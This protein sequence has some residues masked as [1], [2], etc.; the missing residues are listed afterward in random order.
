MQPIS[1]PDVIGMIDSTRHVRIT[2]FGS[3]PIEPRCNLE[4]TRPGL[5]RFSLPRISIVALDDAE[6]TRPVTKHHF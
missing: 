2:Y 6:G 5:Y 1:S 4:W 3:N